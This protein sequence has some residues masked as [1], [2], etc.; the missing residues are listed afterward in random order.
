GTSYASG[1]GFVYDADE[2]D[3]VFFGIAPR[4]ALTIDPQQRLLLETS[5][6]AIERA[7]I[8]PLSLKGSRTGVFAGSNGQDYIGLLLAAPGGPEGY[9]GTGN[10][11]SV[12]SGRISYTFGLEG[13]AVTV[14]TACSSSLVALH[15]AVQSLRQGESSL[16]LAGG[17]TIMSSPGSF[18]DFSRQKGLS[19]DGRCKAFAASADGTGW[20]EG[21]GMLLLERL[22]DARRNGH[23]VMAIVRGSAV[24]QDGAS[25]GITAPN[26]PSQQ[27]VIRQALASADLAAHQVQAVEAHGTGTRLGDPIEAQALLATYGQGRPENEPLWLGSIKSNIGHTQAAAGVAGIIKMVMAMREGVLPQTLH[28]DEPTPHVDWTAGEV[29]LLTASTPWPENGEP[30]RAGISSFG[31]SGTNAHTIIEQA[32]EPEEPATAQRVRTDAP[33]TGSETLPWTVNGKGAE[34]LRA[35]A[36]N[37]HDY[38]T[39]HP[40]LDLDDVGYS[41]ATTRSAFDHRA[42]LLSGDRDGLLSG[43]DAIASGATAPGAVQGSVGTAG[44][45]AFLFSGQGAQRLG[46]GR[47]LYDAFPVFA[48]ALDEVCAHL[49]VLLDRPLQEVMFAAEDS[50]DAELLDQTAFTQP[51]LFAIEVALFRLLEHWGITPDVLIGHSV[52]EVAAAHVA[53]VLSLEDA[54]ALIVARGR[55]MQALPEGGA[56]VAVQASE[57]EIAGSLAGRAAELSIAAVNGPTAVV[58]AGDEAAAL[59]IAGEWERQG[60]KTRRLT[61]SHAFHSP[62]MDA[63][64]DDFR[65]IVTGLSFQAPSISLVSNLTGKPAGAAEVCSPE[66]WVRHVREA[67]RFADGVRALEKLGVTSFLEVGPDGVLTAMAQDCLAADEDAG[68]AAF[69]LVPALRKNRPETQSLTTALAEL[70]VHGTTVDWSTAFAG[71][72]VRRVE[73]PTYAFQ[74][75]RYWP[76]APGAMTGDV[77]SIGLSSPNHPLLGAGVE[78]AGS[79]GF[80]FTSRLSVQSQPWLAD[81]AIGGAALFPGTGFLELAIRA[82]DQVGSGRVEEVTLATP[83]VLPE[84]EPVQVQ[85]WVGDKDETGYRSLSLYSRS[86]NASSDEPWTQHAAGALAPAGPEPSFDLSAWPPADAEALDISDFYERFAATGFA[87]GPVFQGLRAAWRSGDDVYVEVSLGEHASEAADFGLHPALLDAAVQAVTFVALEDVGLSRLPFSWSGVSL[88]A[89]GASTLRVRLSR[90]GPDSISLAVADGT[91]RPVASVESLVLRPVSVEHIDAAR[92]AAFRD[93]LF[94]LDWTPVPAIAPAEVAT[95][96]WAVVGTDPYGLAAGEIAGAEVT[97]YADL[98]A[99]GAAIDGGA[100]APEAVLVSYAPGLDDPAAQGTPTSKAKGKS[101]SKAKQGLEP[102]GAIHAVTHHTLGMIQGWLGDRRFASS[103]LVFVTSGAMAPEDRDETPDMI[104]APLWGMVRSAQSENPNCFVLVDLDPQEPTEASKAALATVLAGDEPQAVVREGTVL[105]QRMARVSSGTALLPPAGVR[106]WRLDMH[107][108]G[109]LENLALLPSPDVTEELG[110]TEIRVA[111]RA[112]GL[113]FRDVLNALGMYPGEAGPLGGEGAGV[114]T[115]VGSAVTDLAPG[116]PVMG[117][118]GGSFGP[119]AITDRRVVARVPEGWTF[120]QAASTPIVFL[121]AYYAM[122]DLAGLE[123]GQSV[124]VH[125]AAGGVGM[126]TLQLARHLGAEVFGT[127]SEGKW[128]TLRALGLDDE[129]IASSRTLDFEKRFLDATGGR[130]MDV[131]L[132]SLAREFVDAGLRLLPR[133]GRFLEMGKTDIRVPDEVAA[134]YTGVSYQAFDLMEA[135]ADRIHEMWGVLI[136]LFESGVLRP[137]P[138]RTWDVRRAPDAFRFISQARHTG[139]VALTIPRT[140]DG[141]GTVLIT[142]GT[143]GLGALLARHLV[144]EHGVRSVVLTSRRGVEAPGAAELVA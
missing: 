1:G 59:E 5:W 137:L 118:F 71:R 138:V 116:D 99:L 20:A 98:E 3:P 139:K 39:A 29:R 12:V 102:A 49:D 82:A 57:E 65:D 87:Y 27:R 94:T 117:I 66:Y 130:G 97:A 23:P 143:G 19:T 67:V 55:L 51:A 8:D 17:V 36:R 88:H 74:R 26:G 58:I 34:A 129:H 119:V 106:E 31:I 81:H 144:V 104:H 128:D 123:A 61:V 7:G 9:L 131:V 22:S 114:V 85:L 60:R 113:N 76:K 46:M 91:G 62:R 14:D 24:N 37:L 79:D 83:M 73:L 50:A 75:Q 72:D 30:R 112:A 68:V 6:E 52:G 28:V 89:G 120:E 25:N 96:Q 48:R 56:M 140:L 101:K 125:S 63:M 40:E 41:L 122:V 69:T 10:S 141:P 95:A 64:L 2:F 124:L 92:T 107:A 105:G 121:T 108:K 109:T 135:G 54:C 90:L 103:R 84:N 45:T 93:S 127:A 111:L 126:A 38:V 53:G 142:G 77:A 21:V 4:E 70:H 18:V 136:S 44:K 47:E 11:G 13:P 80:L 15:M 133:G 86:A 35:Q 33:P 43:L 16:A 42:V 132:D 110:A 78:L 134:E 100:A 115:E 32:P